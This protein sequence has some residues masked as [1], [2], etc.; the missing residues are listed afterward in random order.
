M[1]VMCL[2]SYSVSVSVYSELA[3]RCYWVFDLLAARRR[4]RSRSSQGLGTDESSFYK[5]GAFH[6]TYWYVRCFISQRK[7]TNLNSSRFARVTPESRLL[8]RPSWD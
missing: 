7:S 8:E 4:H 3:S 6:R 2:Y 5:G 1:S